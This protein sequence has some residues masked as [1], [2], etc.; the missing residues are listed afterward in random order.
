VK[1]ELNKIKDG[2]VELKDVHERLH[3]ISKDL[4][5]LDLKCGRTKQWAQSLTCQ[6]QLMCKGS[7]TY[8]MPRPTKNQVA[9]ATN[10]IRM[11]FVSPCPICG[12]FFFCNNIV[13]TLCECIYHPFCICGYLA[14]KAT[15]C[16]TPG[17]G[18]TFT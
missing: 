2:E 1:R 4:D 8:V 7:G 13:L 14:S 5:V 18:Q 6:V 15:K 16:A 11:F 9:F 10:I 17:C 3:S 12:L